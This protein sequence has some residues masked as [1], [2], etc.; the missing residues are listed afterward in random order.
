MTQTERVLD[1]LQCYHSITALDALRD[2]WIMR[3]ASRI[4]DLRR[5]G[6]S[7]RRTMIEVENRFG[8]KTR[9]ARYELEA[10]A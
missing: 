9:V 6:Y 1:Y 4:S 5:A 7:I 2:L 8:G 3:L 10:A